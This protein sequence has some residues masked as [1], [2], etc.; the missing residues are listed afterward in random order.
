M[1]RPIFHFATD[2]RVKFAV[3]GPIN[4]IHGVAFQA[5]SLFFLAAFLSSCD[6]V[7]GSLLA[8]STG[9]SWEITR[10]DIQA[11]NA[12]FREKVDR[13]G[14]LFHENRGPGYPRQRLL[15]FQRSAHG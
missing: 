1:V 3:G 12:L 6:S 4:Q 10:R 7:S 9:S 5:D 8:G 13:M 14:I 15:F 11:C 2:E